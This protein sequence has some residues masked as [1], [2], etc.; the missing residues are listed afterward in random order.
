MHNLLRKTNY[1]NILILIS[2]GIFLFSGVAWAGNNGLTKSLVGDKSIKFNG[3]K[4][5]YKSVGESAPKFNSGAGT[6]KPSVDRA[7]AV[8]KPGTG[9]YRSNG[10]GNTFKSI[11]GGNTIKS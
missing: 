6:F 3:G 7:S 8:F 10:N 11:G 2:I 1:I 5:S 9:F 4:S